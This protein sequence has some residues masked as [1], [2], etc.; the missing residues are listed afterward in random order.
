M[1]SGETV[2]V[3]ESGRCL[4]RSI[5]VQFHAPVRNIIEEKSGFAIGTIVGA[6]AGCAVETTG[7]V[8]NPRATAT[9]LKLNKIG[10]FIVPT[11]RPIGESKGPMG[12]FGGG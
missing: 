9:V 7:T 4:P 10:C 6:G 11:F 5:C 2:V 12:F 1:P 8:M 3:V